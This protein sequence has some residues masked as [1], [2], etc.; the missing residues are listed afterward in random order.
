M[1]EG[2]TFSNR[3]ADIMARDAAAVFGWRYEPAIIFDRGAGVRI[4]DLDGKAY[5]DMSS[6]MMSLPLGH[7]HPEVVEVIKRQAETL[8]HQSSW[9]SNPWAVEFAELIGSTLPGELKVV[10][11]AV[12]G[13]EANE[14][15]MRMALAVTGKFDVVSV[16]RGLHGGSLA[17]ESLTTV[18]GGRRQ[19]LG[20]LTLPASAPA[21]LPP[22]CYRCPVNS[23]YPSCDVACLRTSEDLIE[24]TT[25]KSVAAIISEPMLVAGGMIVP[26]AEWLPRLKAIAERWGALLVLDEAQ[27]APG[28]TGKLWGFQNYDVVP[29]VVTFGK[30]LGGGLAICGAVTT[31]AIAERVSG[32]LGLPWSGTF[33]ADPLP[34]AVALKSLEIVLRDNLPEHAAQLGAHLRKRLEGLQDKFPFIGDVR[35]VGLYQMLDFVADRD[36]KRPDPVAAERVRYNAMR[37]GVALICVKNFIRLCPPLIITEAE[38]DDAMDRL[39]RACEGAALGEP[40]EVMH[41]RSSSLASAER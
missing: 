13:S 5:F 21:I 8:V 34:S 23:T 25:S 38:L 29:D 1:A 4:F 14:V 41:A 36:S 11:Y 27:L 40:R 10:N 39:E 12:T 30:G 24:H 37:E 2:F 31:P 19:G 9:Y 18:G 32:R 15:A 28:R 22:F 35:G 20:P 26:P 3:H 33:P 16:V 6:G 7:A 17:A